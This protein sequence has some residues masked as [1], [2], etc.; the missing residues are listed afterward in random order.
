MDKIEI[1]DSEDYD[2]DQG[3]FLFFDFFPKPILMG[4]RSRKELRGKMRGRERE[5]T[6][7]W[8]GL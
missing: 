6:F 2:D 8:L 7:H 1:L 3:L 5:R 4:L